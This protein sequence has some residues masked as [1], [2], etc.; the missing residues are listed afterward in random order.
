MTAQEEARTIL[1]AV[2]MSPKP[3]EPELPE[4]IRECAELL[5][6]CLFVYFKVSDCIDPPC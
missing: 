4:I 2:W 3:W 5:I 1:P 6:F